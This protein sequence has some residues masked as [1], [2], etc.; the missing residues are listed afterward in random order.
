MRA[1]HVVLGALAV[2]AVAC[3]AF[4]PLE[5]DAREAGIRIKVERC[6]QDEVSEVVSATFTVRS[7]EDYDVVLVNGRL[8]DATGLVVATSSTSVSNVRPDEPVQGVMSLSPQGSYERPLDCEITL[9]F[10]QRP[11]FE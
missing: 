3:S 4:D 5:R 8:K 10:A 6:E 2:L 7:E 11:V 9:E 1:R